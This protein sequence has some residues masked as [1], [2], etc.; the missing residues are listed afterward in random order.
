[1][2]YPVALFTHAD[3][4]YGRVEEVAARRQAALDDAY[5]QH[6]ERFANGPPVVRRP[7]TSVA[8]NPL[9]VDADAH[10]APAPSPTAASLHAMASEPVRAV[11]AMLPPA[12][13]LSRAIYD[14]I[15]S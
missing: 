5:A 15:P 7:P 11:S 1:M 2:L 8:I 9:S 14:T 6:P 13:P 12:R 4:F 3:V 10:D